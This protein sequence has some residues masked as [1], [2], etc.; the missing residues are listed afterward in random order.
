MPPVIGRL[1][2][3][4]RLDSAPTPLRDGQT[5]LA[6]PMVDA[7]DCHA[8]ATSKGGHAVLP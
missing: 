5:K 6:A 3:L 4:T 1:R 2:G 8:V 7:R